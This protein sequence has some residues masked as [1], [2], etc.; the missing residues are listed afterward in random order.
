[1]LVRRFVLVSAASLVVGL[2]AM[3]GVVR[4]EE[5]L[6]QTDFAAAKAKAK[7]ENK[8]LLVDF[9]G[10]EWCG[11][12]KKLVAEVFSK[13]AFKTAAPK[14]F[15][16]VELD[17]PMSP[18]S[19]KK[20]SAELRKQNKELL[21][22]YRVQ[23]YPSILLMEADGKVIAH[24][25]YQPG[26]PEEYVKHLA[27]FIEVF[28][29]ILK[30]RAELDKVQGVDR[31]KLL[32]KV[33]DVYINKLDNADGNEVL[34]IGKE[35][36]ALDPDNK[37]GLKT[38]HQFKVVMI[39]FGDL[40][41]DM[42]FVEAVACLKKGIAAIG[43]GP[44]A[45]Q[46]KSM[47]PQFQPMADAQVTIAKL[48]PEL[49][50]VKGL[51]RAKTLDKLIEAWDKINRMTKDISPQEVDKWSQEIVTLDADNKAGLQKKYEF[52]V[53]MSGVTNLL[54]I[55]KVA[56]AR[57]AIEKAL[58]LPGLVGEQIQT[59]H[60]FMGVSYLNEGNATKGYE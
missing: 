22:Q 13:D 44:Q 46:L 43:D 28:G 6:W 34:A 38:K 59:G 55:G 47:L 23:G 54:Q 37:S 31:V 25:G 21:K 58:A 27:K 32:D 11:W 12:C 45:N 18:A 29:D 14:K 7:A 49:K 48:K 24:T 20:Q 56:E 3:A 8:L 4:A 57:T 16:L 51:D 1:M 36:V 41:D 10:S 15:V 26:G 9:T 50:N 19:I 17:Y 40:R 5:S 2:F 35:I 52:R 33:A 60:F 30:M 42:N 53:Q 39:E